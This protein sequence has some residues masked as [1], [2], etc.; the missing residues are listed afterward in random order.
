MTRQEDAADRGAAGCVLERQLR[1]DGVKF[2]NQGVLDGLFLRLDRDG[3][4]GRKGDAVRDG[5]QVDINPDRLVGAVGPVHEIGEAG[6]D[7][8]P[9]QHQVGI[10]GFEAVGGQKDFL[11]LEQTFFGAGGVLEAGAVRV[12]LNERDLVV[13]GGE[14]LA[15]VLVGA[16]VLL[17]RLEVLQGCFDNLAAGGE[18][19]GQRSDGFVDIEERPVGELEDVVEALIGDRLLGVGLVALGEGEGALLVGE[20]TLRGFG[21]AGG[22]GEGAL[23]VGERT[24]RGF[25]GAG[26]FGAAGL[27]EGE[28]QACDKRKR[29]QRGHCDLKKVAGHALAG[30][31]AEGVFAGDDGA[32]FEG[33]AD[34]VGE[35]R[36]GLIALLGL[37]AERHEDD[38]VEVGRKVE[39]GELLAADLD[40]A[41]SALDAGGGV[42]IDGLDALSGEQLVEH[43][44]EGVDVGG[45]GDGEATDL[46][47]AGVAGGEGAACAG[48]WIVPVLVL[49]RVSADQLGDAEVEQLGGGI[50]GDKDV[51]GLQ[52]AVDDEVAVGVGDGF[53]DVQEEVAA[54]LDAEGILAAEDVD[55]AAFYILHGEEGDAVGGG[56]AVEQAGNIRVI[57]I[58]EDLA[59]V[60]EAAQD[61]LGVHAALDDFEGDLLDVFLV[62]AEGEIDGAHA[63]AAYLADDAIGAEALADED[64]GVEDGGGDTLD[65]GVDGDGAVVVGG[66]EGVDLVE[67]L[68]VACAKDSHGIVPLL[69]REV[70]CGQE[71]ALNALPIAHR[72]LGRPY[73]FR[74][75]RLLCWIAGT[76]NS[77]NWK[78]ILETI[79][80][81]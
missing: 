20:R 59:L 62:V 1:I 10:V 77:E 51:G 56:P 65:G 64:G 24:L 43:G 81:C 68:C 74:D 47:G 41:D 26:G 13:G 16:D 39:F 60:A 32:V 12:S 70:R 9:A 4:A 49:F 36:G 8:D 75:F 44:A 2:V 6:P 7:L 63:A 78:Q 45:G 79:F 3:R 80:S 40:V 31:V 61:F 71:D 46:L 30:E 29:N 18:G 19:A 23:L 48:G 38:V 50:G 37:F 11:G 14:G 42:E 28:D 22:F 27:G 34:V 21:G 66:E 55:G 57:Q 54:G 69:G 17:H 5:N 76:E 58:C 52:I 67:E 25:G 15:E 33:A 73:T 72:G 35:L 53:E